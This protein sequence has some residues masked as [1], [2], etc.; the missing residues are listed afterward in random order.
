[1][2]PIIKIYELDNDDTIINSGEKAET[3][4]WVNKTTGKIMAFLGGKKIT[5]FEADGKL[6]NDV[7]PEYLKNVVK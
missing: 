4:I 6:S 7:I 2:P 1:M 3:R 5:L